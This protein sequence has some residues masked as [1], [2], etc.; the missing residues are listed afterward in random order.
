VP[1]EH[2]YAQYLT[3]RDGDLPVPPLPPSRPDLAG[4]TVSSDVV[5][6]DLLGRLRRRLD[7]HDALVNATRG[8]LASLPTDPDDATHGEL[9]V[10]VRDLRRLLAEL[11][12]GLAR[13]AEPSRSTSD[14]VDAINYAYGGIV[15]RRDT[16]A[17]ADATDATTADA[18]RH[19]RLRVVLAWES[20]GREVR[21]GVDAEDAD[22]TPVSLG[23]HHAALDRVA[24][25]RLV[26][27]AEV[28]GEVAWPDPAGPADRPG[29]HDRTEEAP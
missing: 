22:G 23:G 17:D 15:R 10:A 12:D 6:R 27:L 24:L 20:G 16:D 4:P 13:D 25:D 14:A 18:T 1:R 5:A 28:A 26:A 2:V 8:V 11:D 21:L 19:L 3:V 9:R 7:V 29:R